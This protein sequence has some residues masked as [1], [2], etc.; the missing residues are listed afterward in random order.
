MQ[1][2]DTAELPETH[3]S[4]DPRNEAKLKHKAHATQVGQVEWV[5]RCECGWIERYETT[6][7]GAG[8][9]CEWHVAKAA[10][11]PR[12]EALRVELE[13]LKV[14]LAIYERHT[15]LIGAA[16]ELERLA[17][18]PKELREMYLTEEFYGLR[19]FSPLLLSNSMKQRAAQLRREAE[20]K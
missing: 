7:E 19:A 9:L 2:T 15:K 12:D 1:P 13:A 6:G 14:P 8:A 18:S 17:D 5:C 11:D 3:E 20:E 10:T 16:E 4:T